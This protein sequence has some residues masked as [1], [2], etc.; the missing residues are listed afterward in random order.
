MTTT[1]ASRPIRV[2]VEAAPAKIRQGYGLDRI[3][4]IGAGATPGSLFVEVR[5]VRV[6]IERN[7]HDFQS[8]YR[9]LTWT[10]ER[11]WIEVASILPEA[12]DMAS[13]PSYV[14][15]DRS[16]RYPDG[17]PGR[18]ACIAAVEAVAV[19]LVAMAEAVLF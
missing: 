11:G 5:K 8:H 15:W 12:D 4:A 6:D 1:L 9:A 10:D 14:A 3:Y 13:M 18:A 17:S 7:A 19:R 2:L 16:A